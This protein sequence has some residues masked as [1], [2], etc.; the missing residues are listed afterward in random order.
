[1][2][3]SDEM[4]R[5]ILDSLTGEAE[6]DDTSSF[7]DI[8]ADVEDIGDYGRPFPQ[9]WPKSRERQ[10]L[11]FQVAEVKPKPVV[12]NSGPFADSIHDIRREEPN[13]DTVHGPV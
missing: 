9:D 3:E 13:A 7:D 4:T 8:W 11:G 6:L 10:P 5:L 2:V 1:M 12:V